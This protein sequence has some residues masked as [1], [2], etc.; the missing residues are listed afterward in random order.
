[1]EKLND[2]DVAVITVTYL[3]PVDP[4][5]GDRSP[6]DPG[7][8]E[9]D[10]AIRPFGSALVGTSTTLVYSGASSP[11]RGQYVRTGPGVYV[12]WLDTTGKPGDWFTAGRSTGNAQ[13]SS[14]QVQF[15]VNVALA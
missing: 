9:L 6:T 15:Q 5:T 1:L 10:Y 13:A 2:G 3:G 11:A 12:G 8:A 4:I 14:R 7:T